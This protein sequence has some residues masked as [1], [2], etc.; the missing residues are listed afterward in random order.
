[1]T[2]EPRKSLKLKRIGTMPSTSPF[3]LSLSLSLSFLYAFVVGS[4][5]VA[6]PP[7]LLSLFIIIIFFIGL[8]Q[9]RTT[10]MFED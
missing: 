6:A 7:Q 10:T 2:I 9:N 3:A 1:M 8:L 4:F 5:W